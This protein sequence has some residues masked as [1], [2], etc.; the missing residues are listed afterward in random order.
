MSFRFQEC[1][2]RFNT[3]LIRPFPNTGQGISHAAIGMLDLGQYS[4]FAPWRV[5]ESSI[6]DRHCLPAVQARGGAVAA[7]P[8]ADNGVAAG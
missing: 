6:C 7:G 8:V 5:F 4:G 3:D 1:V 2:E